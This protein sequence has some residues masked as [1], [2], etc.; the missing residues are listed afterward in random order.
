MLKI[1]VIPQ[2]VIGGK[3]NCF[4]S[5]HSSSSFTDP[6]APIL[7]TADT[8]EDEEQSDE[9]SVSSET[10]EIDNNLGTATVDGL[11][12]S[13]RHL[14]HTVDE[15]LK[16][17]SEEQLEQAVLESDIMFAYLSQAA[18]EE[19][20]EIAPYIPE[21]KNIRQI[22]QCP[23]AIRDSWLK[24]LRKEIKFVIENKTFRRGE[25]PNSDDEVIPS[26]VIYKAK[27]TSKGFL[28]KLKAR[29]VARGDFQS[30]SAPEDT[31]A[32][33][34]FGRTF[35]VF[36][37]RAVKHNR[38]VKQ[39]DFIGAFCQGNMQ[40]R[41]FLQL[42]R[43]YANLF[44]EYEEFFKQPLLLDKSLYGIDIAHKV[45]ADDLHE[46]LVE[47]NDMPFLHS[48]FDPSLYIYRNEE[49][50]EYLYL[51]CYVDDCL[52][53]GS[54]DNVEKN[55]GDIL[56]KRFNLELQGHAHW[57]LGTRIY[58][59]KD[60]SYLIDQETYARHVLNRYC[61][62]DS[63]W[64]LPP[65]KSS[66]APLD[67]VYSK[68][69]RPTTDEDKKELSTK[70]E[71]LSMASAVSSFLYIVLNT[72]S[73]ILWIVNKLAKSSSNPGI[74]DYEALMHCFGYLRKFPDMAIK[75]YANPKESPV[76]Q[77][78]DKHKVEFTDIIGFS[79]SSWQ[80][81]P[82]TGRSTGGY[83]VFCQGGLID[84]NSTMPI[85]VALSSAE[86]E[87]MS[88]CNLGAMIYHLRELL[89]EFEFLG[90]SEYHMDGL[91]GTAPTML[92]IDNQATVSMSK[93]Y[94]V[95]SKNRHIGRRWH[96][97]RRGVQGKLFKL[98]WIPAAD[99]L[100]DDLT[101]TQQASISSSHVIR[102]LIKVPEMVKGF[103]SSTVGNR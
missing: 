79:D 57:F 68:A 12:R 47:N 13:V 64:G 62:K 100:A 9:D 51:I 95:T 28:D 20:I 44:P 54:S 66:P 27:I 73:D 75:F 45:F 7:S 52:Y 36:I 10:D 65:M 102:T 11:R 87:Y 42:P 50:K 38:P 93:N 72:R 92:L 15:D 17:M 6:N 22:F 2:S 19:D 35:K 82:D 74:K 84:A 63:P 25:V 91:F 88:C 29:L 96:F 101:K 67:Y 81:C 56:M 98:Q 80:D 32:P 8:N 55:L 1:L 59:E 94:K 78:C 76:Y 61:G 33:C 18:D 43:E 30:P 99:Q 16:F 39:L 83:K 21:P 31:W 71:G 14:K 3:D 69:N 24:A 41:L 89:Y 53:F 85:P 103:K 26:M 48:E 4:E 90:T 77:I 5:E 97:V 60:G 58:R 86:A 40:T 23:P 37:A 49:R 34:V 70:L 46:W